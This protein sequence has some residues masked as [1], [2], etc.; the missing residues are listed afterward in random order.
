MSQPEMVYIK[1]KNYTP[2]CYVLDV[3]TDEYEP[4][5]KKGSQILVEPKMPESLELGVFTLSNG[6][7]KALFMI[8]GHELTSIPMHP[9]S[10]AIP[11]F[12]L[13][14]VKKPCYLNIDADKLKSAHRAVGIIRS[15]GSVRK[16][17]PFIM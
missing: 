10:T 4:Y 12:T 14:R 9:N 5:V 2:D 17:K 15:D 13:A 16:I 1:P 11:I 6:S 7:M 8:S 3:S